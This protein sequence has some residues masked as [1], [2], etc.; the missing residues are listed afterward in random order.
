MITNQPDYLRKKN[1]KKNIS[2]IN[3]YLKKK[4][5]LD[6]IFVCFH[7]DSSNCICRKPK[8]GMLFKAKKKHNINLK[9]SYFIG[10]RWRDI[11][12]SKKTK[13]KKRKTK[14]KKTKRKFTNSI[15]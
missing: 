6:D 14:R 7:D 12:A 15:L 4:L 10:D 11:E 3:Y 2:Q 5:L 9:Q 13:C 1:S 8:P